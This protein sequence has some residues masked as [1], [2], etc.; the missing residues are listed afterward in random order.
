M[1]V[2]VLLLT[3]MLIVG[4][5][6]E[7]ISL[8]PA[9]LSVGSAELTFENV[10]KEESESHVV[11]NLESPIFKKYFKLAET[12][13]ANAQAR[14][15][16]VYEHASQYA[17]LDKDTLLHEADVWMRRAAENGHPYSQYREGYRYE[18]GLRV[19]K[20]FSVAI[21]WYEK[22]ALNGFP[23]AL[24]TTGNLYRQPSY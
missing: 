15:S 8:S 2:V 9:V 19:K 17:V 18:A 23:D 21:E 20:D 11:L 1:R 10:N 3:V 5:Q 22:A 24:I 4:C 12:G 7:N 13:D 16:N 14:V 6:K